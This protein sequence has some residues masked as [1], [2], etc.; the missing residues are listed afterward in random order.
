M[1]RHAALFA[2]LAA[3][4]RMRIVQLLAKHT[5]CVGALSSFFILKGKTP[6]SR[7]IKHRY[8]FNNS[9]PVLI[10]PESAIPTTKIKRRLGL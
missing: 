4:S 8:K 2:A 3:E 10:P 5:L 1:E 6:L 7:L 9:Y